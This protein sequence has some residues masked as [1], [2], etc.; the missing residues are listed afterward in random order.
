MA[1][2]P[3]GLRLGV[4]AVGGARVGFP[5]TTAM[6]VRPKAVFLHIELFDLVLVVGRHGV[7][8]PDLPAL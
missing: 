3:V 7:A 1:T 5:S 6:E 4:D 8:L 2:Q